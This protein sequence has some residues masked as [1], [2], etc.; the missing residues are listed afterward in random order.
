MADIIRKELERKIAEAHTQAH[1][2]G[3][4]E[5][6]R[7]MA[8]QREAQY[9]RELKWYLSLTPAPAEKS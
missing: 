3:K 6:Q 9:K 5:K 1:N 7:Y 8:S 2:A 4:T